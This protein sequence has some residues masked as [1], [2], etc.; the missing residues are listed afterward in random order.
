M[1]TRKQGR[2]PATIYSVAQL[3]G[4]SIATVSRVLQGTRATSPQTRANVLRAVE[5]LAYVPLQA[6]RSLA[7]HRH[8]AHGI[9]VPD[10]IGPY[11]SELLMGYESAAAELGQSVVIVVAQPSEEATR[12]IRLSSRVDG[13]VVANS[14]ISDDAARSLAQRTPVV[15]L[16]RPTV[17]GCDAVAAENFESARALTEHL[18]DHGRRRLSFVGDPDGSPDVQE[19]FLGFMEAL[20]A[21]DR[22]AVGPIV[23]VG[24]RER[25]GAEVA[26]Q[27]LGHARRPDALVC[28][29]DE[30]ALATMKALQHSGIRI[31]EDIAIVGWDDVMT[32]RYV[33]PGLTTV[34]Q[35]LYELGRAAATRLHERIAGAPTA[36]EPLILPT[37]LVLRTSCGCPEQD[38][39]DEPWVTT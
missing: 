23:K 36:P 12:A 20:S 34:R 7:V 4:V 38:S 14:A 17:H 18:L 26:S 28:A 22:S 35:P 31:P 21:V 27:V 8:E 10:L 2:R 39:Y 30:L 3:A 6:A 11:Y 29:N 33:S 13:I 9:I 1:A 16:A 32:A 19:R 37:E 24:F 5:E 25:S 15:L